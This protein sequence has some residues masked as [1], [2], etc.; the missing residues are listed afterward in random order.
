MKFVIVFEWN[1]PRLKGMSI[2]TND[3]PNDLWGPDIILEN[4]QVGC[5]VK[6]DSFSLLDPYTGR[7]KRTVTFHGYV[8]NPMDLIG[9]PFDTDDLEMK[10]ISICNWRTLD[11]SRHGNDPC[12]KTYKLV[13]MLNRPGVDF[14]TLG[15]GGKVRAITQTKTDVWWRVTMHHVSS[16]SRFSPLH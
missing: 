1:D 14:F 10:F 12:R 11:G 15:W 4:A 9:F 6:Y 5:D 2:T 7:L 8:Y 16:Y 3:L 13:P